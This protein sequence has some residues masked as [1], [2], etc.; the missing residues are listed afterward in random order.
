VNVRFSPRAQR[1]VKL[2][3]T[4]W[5]KNRPSA[6]TLFDDELYA[7]IEMLKNKPLLGAGYQMRGVELVRRALLKKSA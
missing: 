1:R 4:W 6:P 7:V 2:V 5:G 3:A